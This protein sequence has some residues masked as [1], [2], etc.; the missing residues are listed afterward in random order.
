[1]G[2]GVQCGRHGWSGWG[3]GNR[4]RALCIHFG[5]EATRAAERAMCQGETSGVG[6]QLAHAQHWKKCSPRGAH[7]STNPTLRDMCTLTF[8]PNPQKSFLCIVEV[9]AS[10][11]WISL[12]RYRCWFVIFSRSLLQPNVNLTFSFSTLVADRSNPLPHMLP[13]PSQ[14]W[15]DVSKLGLQDSQQDVVLYDCSPY[16]VASARAYWMMQV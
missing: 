16:Y 12:L 9:R 11:S 4:W 6:L 14:F 2:Q 5:G 13:S 8:P 10:H 7:H 1:M 3:K 15:R